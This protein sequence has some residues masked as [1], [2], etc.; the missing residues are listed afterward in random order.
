MRHREDEVGEAKSSCVSDKTEERIYKCRGAGP[1]HNQVGR[2]LSAGAAVAPTG[3]SCAF[4]AGTAKT[5]A[6]SSRS[7]SIWLASPPAALLQPGFSLVAQAQQFFRGETSCR[8]I[9]GVGS[10]SLAVSGDRKSVV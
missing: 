9:E 1:D 3:C 4:L 5:P 8:N 10:P 2:D 6:S 7:A